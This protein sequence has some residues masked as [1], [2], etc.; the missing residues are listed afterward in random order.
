MQLSVENGAPEYRIVPDDILMQKY[1][2]T[3]AYVGMSIR[4][5]L[6]GNDDAVLTQEGTEYPIRI[7]FDELNRND[8]DDLKNI[9]NVPT[10]I[11]NCETP[12]A[13]SVMPH[14][15]LASSCASSE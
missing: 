4:N 11:T 2:L 6:T 14:A 10:V 15:R 1:G 12:A 8:Y 3:A 5:A 7:Y 9:P 13:M